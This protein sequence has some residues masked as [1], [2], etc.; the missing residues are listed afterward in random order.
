MQC[1]RW[2]SVRHLTGIGTSAAGGAPLAVGGGGLGLV[3]LIVVALFK[4]WAAVA[5][6]RLAA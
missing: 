4:F 3:S 1:Q 5:A 2:R 6:A